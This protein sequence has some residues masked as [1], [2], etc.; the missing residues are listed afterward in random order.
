MKKQEDD[1]EDGE[2][3][4]AAEPGFGEAEDDADDGDLGDDGVN[5]GVPAIREEREEG[6]FFDDAEIVGEVF[7][8][9]SR[10]SNAGGDKDT[11]DKVLR[12]SI[13]RELGDT[14]IFVPFIEL[15]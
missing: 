7:D 14:P 2:C 9:D 13:C 11:R 15:D 12:E 5:Q 10:G 8:Q 3:D 4:I 1:E 6:A